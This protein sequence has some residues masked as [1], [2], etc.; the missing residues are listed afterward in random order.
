M[1]ALSE[2]DVQNAKVE[3]NLKVKRHEDR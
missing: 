1:L 3:V 2:C